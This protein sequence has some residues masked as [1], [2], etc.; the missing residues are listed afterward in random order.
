MFTVD[1]GDHFVGDTSTPAGCDGVSVPCNYTR[2]GEINALNAALAVI[3]YKQLRGF[4]VED[5]AYYHLLI[6]L[7]DLKVVGDCTPP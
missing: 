6:S 1:E 2:V 7:G 3:R 5:L 4:Y